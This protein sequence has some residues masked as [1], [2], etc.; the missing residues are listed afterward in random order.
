VS[1]RRC[2][3]L[4][5]EKIVS[6]KLE[7][8]LAPLPT[9]HNRFLRNVLDLAKEF[10]DIVARFLQSFGLD[11]APAEVGDFV[12]LRDPFHPIEKSMDIVGS[13]SRAPRDLWPMTFREYNTKQTIV[14]RL[15]TPRRDV[16]IGTRKMATQALVPAYVSIPEVAGILPPVENLDGPLDVQN[17]MLHQLLRAGDA[18]L[19]GNTI[20]I[21]VLTYKWRTYA[22]RLFHIELVIFLLYLII[23][24]AF[25][26]TLVE[27]RVNTSRSAIY[28]SGMGQ[29]SLVLGAIV[30]FFALRQ[31]WREYH[32]LDLQEGTPW[33]RLINQFRDLWS[34]LQVAVSVT[35]TLSV[36]LHF[37]RDSRAVDIGAIASLLIW[38]QTLYFLRAYEST[39]ALVRMIFRVLG[40]SL[41]FLFILLLVVMASS[42]AFI[43]LFAREAAEPGDGNSYPF[44]RDTSVS[45]FIFSVYTA[46]VLSEMETALNELHTGGDHPEIL[47]KVLFFLTSIIVTIFML[48][49]MIN[50]MAEFMAR[51]HQEEGDAYPY[52]LARIIAE[53]E[54]S[55]TT[56]D[57]NRQNFPRWLH[58]LI[59]KSDDMS[60][61]QGDQWKGTAST[62][63]RHNNPLARS[64]INKAIEGQT[65]HLEERLAELESLLRRKFKLLHQP[66]RRGNREYSRYAS[67]G[68]LMRHGSGNSPMY[69]S[70]SDARGI[71]GSLE[72]LSNGMP[73]TRSSSLQQTGASTPRPGAAAEACSRMQRPSMT[74]PALVDLPPASGRPSIVPRG[75]GEQ[76]FD[77]MG[78]VFSDTEPRPA[79][80]QATS[81]QRPFSPKSP[82]HRTTSLSTAEY[83]Y[84]TSNTS[85]KGGRLLQQH[86]RSRTEHASDLYDDS[87]APR[88]GATFGEKLEGGWDIRAD[89]IF[90][91]LT[92]CS[93]L[94]PDEHNHVGCGWS[95]DT[96]SL[97]FSLLLYS[98]LQVY[99]VSEEAVAIWRSGEVQTGCSLVCYR[100]HPPKR[101][102]DP[103][104]GRGRAHR[105][106]HGR[107][108]APTRLRGRHTQANH[109]WA[110]I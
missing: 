40:L 85:D 97:Y 101:R 45:N 76:G 71:S 65:K 104:R 30:P 69:T 13:A 52:E 81:M 57:I 17:S 41:P 5:F 109:G 86:L 107:D 91:L 58:T 90:S 96:Y 80:P 83:P 93:L 37:G 36:L 66:E 29:A 22:R 44:D 74:V 49:L 67:Q 106:S 27:L 11:D 53:L 18:R 43:L 79:S 6:A 32:Q 34:V 19:F 77:Y 51:V 64:S 61:R 48:N 105:Q 47:A 8:R 50:L 26:I 35:T 7:G 31:L 54:L 99:S 60:R 89:T 9:R 108:L 21:K 94:L 2:V 12:R 25:G 14:S 78:Q 28:E 73:A 42:S 92:L 88:A 33:Q 103:V 23:F 46:F 56:K 15:F 39:G 4:L 110:N 1:N 38:M 84:P 102:T 87:S 63:A 3:E 82:Q 10:P 59:P 98:A 70:V 55:M 95:P 24:Q 62:I 72:L 68:N 16:N 75:D 100:R 20:M